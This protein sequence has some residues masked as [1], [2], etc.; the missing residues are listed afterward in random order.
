MEGVL[1]RALRVYELA[2]DPRPS[3]K[4]IL[5]QT[6]TQVRPNAH[7]RK[8]EYMD[9]V[10]VRECTDE[11]FLTPQF[12]NIAPEKLEQRIEELRRFV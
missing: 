9:L 5:A 11:R 3:L 12:R 10:A 8:L 7:T 2:S 1:V 4:E 6:L